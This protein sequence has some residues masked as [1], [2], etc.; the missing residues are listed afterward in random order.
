MS[1]V[2]VSA[3]PALKHLNEAHI[4]FYLVEITDT[5]SL[6]LYAMTC[7]LHMHNTDS[8]ARGKVAFFYLSCIITFTTRISEVSSNQMLYVKVIKHVTG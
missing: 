3:P 5:D 8:C 1:N 4:H 6:Y 7:I 2:D